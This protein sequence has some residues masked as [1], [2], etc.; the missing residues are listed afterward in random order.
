MKDFKYSKI[1][2]KKKINL[3]MLVCACMLPS[4]VIANNTELSKLASNLS[5]R[6]RLKILINWKTGERRWG[7]DEPGV[8]KDLI[9]HVILSGSSHIN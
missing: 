1:K 7:E 8:I 9:E 4:S 5:T 3:C 2:I 6:I